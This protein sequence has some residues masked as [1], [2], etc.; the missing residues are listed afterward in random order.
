MATEGMWNTFFGMWFSSLIL[1]PIG[2]FLTYKAATDSPLF[3]S[4]AWRKTFSNL[5]LLFKK[6]NKAI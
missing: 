3:N 1:L 6:K 5:K 4:E 2:I